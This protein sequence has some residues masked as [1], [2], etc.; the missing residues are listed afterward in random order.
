[1]DLPMQALS[2]SPVQIEDRARM[3][4]L[5]LMLADVIVRNLEDPIKKRRF[6][7][8]AA[9]VV[10]KTGEMS[11]TLCFEK[12][13]LR[14]CRGSIR[15]STA[16]VR[17]SLPALLGLSL[18]K[19]MIWPVLT[20]KIRVGGNL[21]KLLKLKTLLTVTTEIHQPSRFN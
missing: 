2:V 13:A 6:D 12:G 14:V 3:N 4:L 18:G 15:N 8:L 7:R 10:V 1:M 11:V 17:G 16:H 19:S 5:G 21:F 20:G 9:T